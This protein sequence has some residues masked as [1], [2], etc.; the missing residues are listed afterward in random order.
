[1]RSVMRGSV[2]L[3]LMLAAACARADDGMCGAIRAAFA[4]DSRWPT[5]HYNMASCS[6]V[7]KDVEQA[8]AFLA[9]A[10]ARGLHEQTHIETD[11][12]FTILHADPRWR[13][14]VARFAQL[15][16][17]YLASINHELR[18]IYQADQDDRRAGPA[19]DWKVVGPRDTMRMKRV[20]ELASKGALKHSADF[21]HAAFV[22]QHGDK[23]EHFLQAHRWALRAAELD[24]FNKSARWLAC[25]A[26]DRWLQSTGKAQVWG[27]QFGPQG[28]AQP[29]DRSAK[30][31][32]Q[33]TAM[34]VPTLAEISAIAIP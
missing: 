23:P 33:R 26:E 3:A 29:F 9:S 16:S 11:P 18:K 20:R 15:R 4:K 6:A 24:Q 1:M 7:D 22:F 8:F 28:I 27:T 19:I 21:L 17:S 14:T 32:A 34:G 2:L 31:D 12:D 25:A 30:T 10:A 13:P 5:T